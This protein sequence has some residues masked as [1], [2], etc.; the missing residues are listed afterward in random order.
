MRISLFLMIVCQLRN[1]FMLVRNKNILI[2]FVH[3]CQTTWQQHMSKTQDSNASGPTQSPR[4]C[5]V[6]S[7]IRTCSNTCY[8]HCST[9]YNGHH[10]KVIFQIL[11]ASLH[12]ILRHEERN[13]YGKKSFRPPF[14]VTRSVLIKVFCKKCQITQ[15]FLKNL[16]KF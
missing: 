16:P 14:I 10:K 4:Y 5:M 11:Q 13:F 3:F 7:H 15:L 6:I 12:I 1:K 2:W 8:V 9:M